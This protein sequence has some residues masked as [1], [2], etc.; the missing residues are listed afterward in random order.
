MTQKFLAI[1]SKGQ[2]FLFKTHG[3]IAVPTKSATKI[4]DALNENKYRLKD[5]EI[6]HIYDND[7]HYNMMIDYEIKRYGNRMKVYRY[8]SY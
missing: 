3:M 7:Y 4:R 2:E 5:G 1:A 6:W 8:R